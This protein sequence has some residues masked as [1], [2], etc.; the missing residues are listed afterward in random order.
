V[1]RVSGIFPG[2]PAAS[3]PGKRPDDL[4]VYESILRARRSAGFGC[5]DLEEF[6]DCLKGLLKAVAADPDCAIAWALLSKAYGDEHAHGYLDLENALSNAESC[7][8]KAV[9]LDSNCPHAHLAM[10]YV[11]VLQGNRA[12][13]R[14]S[15]GRI[16]QLNPKDAYMVGAGAF[17]LGLAGDFDRALALL[18]ESIGLHPFYPSR[19]HF[20]L[21]M[22]A[23]SC[24]DYEAALEE[25]MRIRMPAWFWDPL[26]RAATLG[27]LERNDEAGRACVELLRIRPDFVENAARYLGCFLLDNRVRRGVSEGLRTAGVPVE[28]GAVEKIEQ[29]EA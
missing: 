3:S 9:T 23:F 22:E 20:I 1:G 25:A 28:G 7:A 5:P 26:L 13:I 21:W 29:A 8:Q 11:G 19:Y 10:T 2:Q 4:A 15:C 14:S 17:F 27:R 18:H 16:L 24:G 6:A 12:L